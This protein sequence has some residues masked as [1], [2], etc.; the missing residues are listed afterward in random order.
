MSSDSFLRAQNQ[1]G[2]F[3]VQVHPLGLQC[4]L[5]AESIPTP[6]CIPTRSLPLVMRDFSVVFFAQ[7]SLARQNCAQLGAFLFLFG[8]IPQDLHGVRIGVGSEISSLPPRCG[9]LHR[10][11]SDSS[12]GGRPMPVIVFVFPRHGM[13]WAR[14]TVNGFLRH[15][16]GVPRILV[17][18]RKKWGASAQL[19]AAVITVRDGQVPIAVQP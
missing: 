7:F 9:P 8:R 3:S 13:S 12:L 18:G 11:S 6:V 15:C 10:C 5:E 17:D 2:A 19:S 1:H 4:V 14:R 16:L